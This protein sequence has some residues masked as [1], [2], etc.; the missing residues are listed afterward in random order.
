MGRRPVLADIYKIRIKDH[1]EDFWKGRFREMELVNRENGEV[2][3]VGPVKDQ[4]ELFEILTKIRDLNL[5]LLRIERINP[6]I[7]LEKGSSELE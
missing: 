7:G 3:L 6:L 1:L 5:A 2:E 4:D